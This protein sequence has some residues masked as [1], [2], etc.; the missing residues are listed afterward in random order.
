M[1]GGGSSSESDQQPACR[2]T[3]DYVPY[4][5]CPPQ[6]QS[7]WDWLWARLLMPVS[8]KTTEAPE[9]RL[10]GASEDDFNADSTQAA[11]TASTPTQRPRKAY[12]ES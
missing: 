7:D 11:A 4:Q 9:P 10:S 1:Q 2:V 3:W 12:H 6:Q 8:P 5:E